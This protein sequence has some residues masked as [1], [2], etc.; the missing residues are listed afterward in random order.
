MA[1]EHVQ[2]RG[3]KHPHCQEWKDEPG[4]INSDQEKAPGLGGRRRCHQKNAGQSRSHTGRPCKA[5]GKAQQKGCYRRHG[6][7]SH[8]KRQPVLPGKEPGWSEDPQLV[9]AEASNK[10]PSD[11]GEHG[12]VPLKEPAQG[13]ASQPQDKKCRAD[14]QHKKYGVEHH[15]LPLICDPSVLSA[16]CGPSGQISDIKGQERQYARREKAQQ[17]L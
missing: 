9:K 1:F 2:K 10:N 3:G 13:R 6:S 15:F 4:R 17:A 16:P 14:P 7:R 8:R 11:P 5:E 12:L